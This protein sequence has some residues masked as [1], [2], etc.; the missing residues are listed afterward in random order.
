MKRVAVLIIFLTLLL[1]ACKEKEILPEIT[2]GP[3]T[4]DISTPVIPPPSPSPSTKPPPSPSPSETPPPS[5]VTKPA[6]QDFYPLSDENFW[7]HVDGSTATIPMSHALYGQFAESDRESHE[8]IYH[9]RTHEA[10]QNLLDRRA[11]L[12]FV[13]EP[14]VEAQKMFDDAGAEIDVI[15]IVKDAFVFLVNDNNPVR[16][17]TQQQLRDIYSGKITN[18]KDVGG[19]DLEI[20]PY[21]RGE[22]SGSQTLFL[23]LL[24]R[25]TKPM[26]APSEYYYAEMGGIIDAVA[27]YKNGDA[28]I[29]FSVFYYAY[30][31]YGNDNVRFLEVDGVLP[32]EESIIAGEYPLE[33][34]YFAVMRKD[35]PNDHPA[36]ELVSW[37]L[38]DDGQTLMRRTGYVPLRRLA[39]LYNKD[40]VE[41][42]YFGEYDAGMVY[43]IGAELREPYRPLDIYGIPKKLDSGGYYS[44][45][46][47]SS[48][49]VNALLDI[50]ISDTL[51][52]EG[53]EERMAASMHEFGVPFNQHTME[54]GRFLTCLVYFGE[55]RDN[56]LYADIYQPLEAY[57]SIC[58]DTEKCEIIDP[59]IVVGELLKLKYMKGAKTVYERTDNAGMSPR[60]DHIPSEKHIITALWVHSEQAIIIEIMDQGN[61]YRYG[62]CTN[63][64]GWYAGS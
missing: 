31:M 53:F 15:P 22:T 56:F 41:P 32:T 18:W 44:H 17:L 40:G 45:P 10:Y 19:D 12:I 42:R 47:T 39:A 51:K 2:E 61:S 13:T 46:L 35:I 63:P 38:S 48:V 52:K 33:S 59:S 62:I 24:M 5:D 16:S 14:S 55:Q 57:A 50:F 30:V 26:Q 8:V 1:S 43:G 34:H 7:W 9:N 3:E 27:E 58:I 37:I 20:I 60:P 11:D 23:S 36:R 21:Q 6:L 29:G 64:D 25:D 28:T 49:K 4:A 54:W